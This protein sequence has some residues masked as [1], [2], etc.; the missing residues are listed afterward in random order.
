MKSPPIARFSAEPEE[1]IKTWNADQSI[2]L[3][4]TAFSHG[5]ATNREFPPCARRTIQNME[6]RPIASW[7]PSTPPSMESRPLSRA[8]DSNPRIFA[9]I[10]LRDLKLIFLGDIYVP[11][12]LS[13]RLLLVEPALGHLTQTNFSHGCATNREFFPGPAE[14]VKTWKADQSRVFP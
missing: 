8:R 4:Q 12:L 1:P 5:C 13:Y 2:D 3:T 11:G 10:I 14:P 6:S 7:G 9:T